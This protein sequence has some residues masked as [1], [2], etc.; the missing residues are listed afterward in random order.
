MTQEM[1]I[2]RLAQLRKNGYKLN[3]TGDACTGDEIAFMVMNY[4]KVGNKVFAAG[5]SVLEGTVVRDDYTPRHV[6][7]IALA[8]GK[9]ISLYAQ[10]M[11][12]FGTY[13]K[14]RSLENRIPFL[15][16]KH[17]R[18]KTTKRRA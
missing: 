17:D 10:T 5:F 6:F 2:K 1:A 16:E 13:A 15:E 11:Y 14:Y 9:R 3:V 8:D 4:A 18:A 7:V 12:R